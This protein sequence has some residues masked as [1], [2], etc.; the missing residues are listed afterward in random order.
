VSDLPVPAA[1]R[2]KLPSWLDARLAV[3]VLLVLASVVAGAKVVA[4]AGDYRSLWAASRD[5][6]PGTTITKGDLTAVKV[7]FHDHGDGYYAASTSL[8]GRT[9][10]TALSAGEL[11]PAA[12]APAQPAARTRL[13]TV[14][15]ARL[16]M[17]GG[18]D[19]HGVQVDMYVTV[20]RSG[21][22]GPSTPRLVLSG[23]TVADTVTDSSLASANGS[24]VVLRVPLRYVDAVLA[25]VESGSIDLVRVPSGNTARTPSPGAFVPPQAADAGVDR[26][27]TRAG[28]SG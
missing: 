24:G 20:R 28:A 16:H 23:V 22:Q 15:V 7:R 17:P 1:S 21:D 13:V 11:I 4:S 3:G 25:A 27:P 8:V 12:A 14:P 19:L 18:H 10:V 9:T 26:T 5:L 2:L 6:A